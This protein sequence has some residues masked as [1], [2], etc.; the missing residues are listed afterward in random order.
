MNK[1]FED[2][3]FNCQTIS[4]KG[5]ESTWITQELKDA[6]IKLHK[7]GYAHSV[8]T[9]NG[10]KLVGGIYG[11]ALGKIFYGESMF[12]LES[13]ASKMAFVQLVEFLKIHNFKL[14][15]CQQ[16]TAHLASL[17]ARSISSKKFLD[18]L[19]NNIFAQPDSFVWRFDTSK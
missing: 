2:V 13:N 15:D 14:I 12:A 9:W 19:R 7:L 1:A 16:E 6:F 8:E 17:G 4:R 3:I 10:D 18:A 11:M 5:Q